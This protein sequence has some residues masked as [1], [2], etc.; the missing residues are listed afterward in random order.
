VQSTPDEE[1][2]EFKTLG[3]KGFPYNLSRFIGKNYGIIPV[4]AFGNTMTF[5]IALAAIG[6]EQVGTGDFSD[7]LAISLST[8]DYLGH[9]FGPNAVE[10]EDIYLRLD[11]DLGDFLRFLDKQVGKGNYMV[12]ISGDHGAAQIPA[13]C[14]ESL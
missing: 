10:S 6:G 9:A 5:E 12:F 1:P 14:M 4:T 13:R 8:P 2:Y 11:K 7:M 3:P